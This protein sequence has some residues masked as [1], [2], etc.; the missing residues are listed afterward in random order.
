M[1]QHDRKAETRA[2]L[3]AAAADLFAEHGIAGASVDAIATRA[4]RTVGAL[5]GHFGSKEEL[6]FAVVDE[7][8]GDAATVVAAELELA[9][10]AE[11]RLASLWRAVSQ[12]SSERWLA[13]EHEV[14][15]HAR[16]NPQAMERLRRRYV[17]TW[18]GIAMLPLQWPEFASA[19]TN[20]PAIVGVLFGM[21]MMHQV[22]PGSITDEMAVRTLHHLVSSPDTEGATP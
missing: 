7:W 2:R 21:A 13:L 19:G 4:D 3:L 10:D 8:L 16:R 17:E 15:S 22:S 9:D 14:W 5:Y 6:L 18:E 11:Q 12:P 1:R 20:A